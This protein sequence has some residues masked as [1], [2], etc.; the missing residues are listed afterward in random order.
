MKLRRILCG[1]FAVFLL[2]TEF[3]GTAL[4][5]SEKHD[6]DALTNY[7]QKLYNGK[8]GLPTS[9]ANTVLQTNDGYI[10]IGGYGGLLRYDGKE[11]RNYSTK[12][13]GLK[14]SGIRALFEDANGMMWVG[15][16][17]KGTY[18]YENN[19]FVP[20]ESAK[21]V[22]LN[23]IRCFA[24][25]SD[26][27]IYVGTTSGLAFIDKNN[28]ITPINV[29]K[30]LN[31]TIYSLS[32]DKNGVIW[33]I[34]GDGFVF[35]V[36]D[37]KMLYWFT[38]DMLSP[39]E[40]YSVLADDNT[41]YI[42]TSGNTLIKLTL[43]DDNYTSNSYK[44]ELYD[45]GALHTANALYK[46]K[47]GD[48]WLGTNSGIGYFDLAMTLHIPQGLSQNTS[49]T[50]LTED[51]E[52]NLWAASTQGGVYQL[53]VGKFSVLT[54]MTGI[55]E[56]SANAVVRL[57]G[58][59]Y[60][61]SDSGLNIL[62]ENWKPVEN[63]L[64]RQMTGMRI[65]HLLADSRGDLWLSTYSDSGL[66]RYTPSTEKILSVTDK[67][68]LLSNRVRQV[69]ELKNGDIGVS[70]TNGVNRLR[71]GKVVESYGQEQGLQNPM[72]L[73]L[74]ET[75]NGTL[76]AGSDGMGIYAIAADGTV[77][78][79]GEKNGL[80]SGVVLRICEDKKADGFWISA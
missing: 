10:W 57:N 13:D 1:A 9:E 77:S 3:S 70:T 38:P 50:D 40:N 43:T 58:M 65:R 31:Q 69:I 19:Q 55:G 37:E 25:D 59:L 68:G 48:I 46:G 20:C 61:A 15:T 52:G 71:D 64:T 41:V 47:S 23:S 27:T 24:Q 36:K 49:L 8:N 5:V 18:R 17:D 45:T 80:T 44:R 67:Q 79:I 35:A 21:D 12:N 4:A 28:V 22:P 66:L 51:Y 76:L 73:C 53:T 14:S 62:D 30:L 6:N 16:N 26:G 75:E 72:I 74:L 56:K 33:G 7:V 11:F 42:G 54:P 34:A 32:V 29:P 78:N 2:F 60:V 39:N 63:E